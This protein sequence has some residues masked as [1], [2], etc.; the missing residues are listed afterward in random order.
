MSNAAQKACR[1]SRAW[2]LKQPSQR[3]RKPCRAAFTACFQLSAG[4]VPP[5]AHCAS[6]RRRLMNSPDHQ[7]A[8]TAKLVEMH[9]ELMGRAGA[10]V[11]AKASA[12][13]K[14][15][16]FVRRGGKLQVVE[17]SEMRPEESAATEAGTVSMPSS[18]VGNLG[19]HS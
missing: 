10:K 11:V 17:Y 15:G 16:V 3:T 6:C 18:R 13:E 2:I 9:M 8:Q 12:E 1:T 14:V 19:L 5:H 4:E 7:L